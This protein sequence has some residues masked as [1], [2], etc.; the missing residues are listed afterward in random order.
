VIQTQE[1]LGIY[2]NGWGDPASGEPCD[3]LVGT[4]RLRSIVNQFGVDLLEFDDPQPEDP[5]RPML[6]KALRLWEI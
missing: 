4:V 6:S 1:R 3:V 2:A 5:P